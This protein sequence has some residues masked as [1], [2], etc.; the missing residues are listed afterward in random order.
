MDINLKQLLNLGQLVLIEEGS[1]INRTLRFG[2]AL[3]I[4]VEPYYGNT[5]VTIPL[6]INT[7]EDIQYV[8]KDEA[9]LCIENNLED[10]NDLELPNGFKVE[11][12]TQAIKQNNVHIHVYP[13]TQL[14]KKEG[15]LNELH[16]T[17]LNELI[18]IG[19]QFQQEPDESGVEVK[20]VRLVYILPTN[21]VPLG[22]CVIEKRSI[23]DNNNF[24]YIYP[25]IFSMDY[26]PRHITFSNITEVPEYYKDKEPTNISIEVPLGNYIRE[27]L[28]DEVLSISK[29]LNN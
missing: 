14:A 26:L 11:M 7:S 18:P 2:K 10:V 16:K 3:C 23:N 19:F 27:L 8:N 13:A 1:G 6:V 12:L 25:S 9:W 4:P 28:P 5:N 17:L 22:V 20:V 21:L 15:L 29:V 24:Y